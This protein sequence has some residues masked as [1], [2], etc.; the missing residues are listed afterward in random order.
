MVASSWPSLDERCGDIV[1][2][3]CVLFG[4]QLDAVR[5]KVA[6]MSGADVRDARVVVSPYRICPLG[7]HIDH[8][9]GTVTAMTINMGLLLGFV[10]SPDAQ[11]ILR[12][13][14]FH[15]EVKFRYGPFQIRLIESYGFCRVDEIQHPKII[16]EEPDWAR[17][18]RGALYALQSK[19]HHLTKVEKITYTLL[20]SAHYR[21]VSTKIDCRQPILKE[22]DRR[23]SIEEEKGKK[24]RK[25]QKK[26]RGEERIPRSPAVVARGS[27]AAAF[28]PAR[29]DG[30]S[31]C[32]RRQIE[33]TSI[34]DQYARYLSVPCVGILGIARKD[35]VWQGSNV[36]SLDQRLGAN[37]V[38][39]GPVNLHICRVIENEYL[40]LKNGILDQSA[41]LLSKYGY[42]TWMDC[43]VW[44]DYCWT[45]EYDIAN[46]SEL[47]KCQQSVG[48]ATYKILL[49]FSGLKEPLMRNSGYNT[50][51]SECREAAETLL[52]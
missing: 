18:P 43:K 3:P 21:A 5:K 48:Q 4:T 14:Q 41:I 24:K 44:L 10:P 26:R 15:G 38:S 37:E 27:P 32:A 2:V 34:E 28:S 42:L 8:Q 12:S 51:V 20:I 11:V 49:A 7:A 46:F 30:A 40:H 6:E 23:R 29:G 19:G 9:G 13:G 35:K 31:P 45:R 22:I 52:E 25:K 17:Y 33:A 50:R 1:F 16:P 47:Q 39:S 36:S